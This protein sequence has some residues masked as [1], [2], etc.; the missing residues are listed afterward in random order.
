MVNTRTV[1]PAYP[2]QDDPLLHPHLK[3]VTEAGGLQ[4][5]EIDN[6]KAVARIALQGAHVV[7][8]RP[9]T[10]AQPVLWLSDQARYVQGR[11]IRGGVPVCWP[12][13][14]AHPTDSTLC[15]HGFARVIPW[16]L[17]HAASTESGATRLV[18]QMQVTPETERQLSYPFRLVL[19]IT[20]GNRLKLDLATTNLAHHPFVIGEAYHTYFNVSDIAQIS[21]TGLED[22]M[23]SDKV[24]GYAR[25][26]E[27]DALFFDREFDRVFLNHNGDCIL[28]DP[29]YRRRIRISKSGSNT[30]VVWT[31]WADKAHATGDM[32]NADEW[33]HMVCIETA[34]A[35]ENMVVINPD[36]THV[37][38]AEYSV[39]EG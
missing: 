35:L 18:L 3:L 21:V 22:C 25:Q 14:G 13:F 7:L 29:G 12:W 17:L 15:A 24:A 1:A 2:V 30:T 5:L 10:Q 34:N 32:G 9:K 39:E 31:P 16:E 8:W 33:R 37:L 23:Y 11:S 6:P 4:F 27:H 28:N 26:I 20:I 19:T 36:K 38:T